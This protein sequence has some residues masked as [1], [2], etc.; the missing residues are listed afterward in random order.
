MRAAAPV[1]TGGEKLNGREGRLLQLQKHLRKR[2]EEAF[3]EVAERYRELFE[4]ANDIVYTT[5]LSG[6]FTSMNQAGLRLTGYPEDEIRKI[7]ITQ[8][9]SP[10]YLAVIRTMLAHI[11]AGEDPATFVIEIMAKDG[12]RVPLEVSNQL[13]VRGGKAVGFQGIGRN[14]ARRRQ[15]EEKN[16]RRAILMGRLIGLTE[17]LN[18]P[19]TEG[20]AVK[21]I[22]RGALRLSEAGRGALLVRQPDGTVACPWS[23]GISRTSIAEVIA[24]LHEL[25]AGFL[26]TRAIEDVV[27]LP[28]GS[29]ARGMKPVLFPDLDAAPSEMVSR[30]AREEGYRAAGVW[31][32]RSEGRVIALMGCYYD[33]PRTWSKPELDALRVFFRQAAV[34]LENARLHEARAQRTEELES[35]LALSTRLRAAYS[36]EEMYPLLVEHARQVLRAAYGALALLDEPRETFTRIHDTRGLMKGSG[37][38]PVRGSQLGRVVVT[39]VPLCVRDAGLEKDDLL[40][41]LAPDGPLGPAVV[42]PVRS[43]DEIIGALAIGRAQ[44]PGCRPFTNGDLSVLHG[45][46]EMGGTAIQRARLDRNLQ[47]ADVQMVLALAR[48]TAW[49]DSHTDLHNLRLVTLAEQIARA[50]GLGADEIEEIRWGARLHDIGKVGVPDSILHKPGPLTKR[51]QAVMRRH[52]MIG[53]EILARVERMRGVAKLVRHHQERWNG[54]GYPD[55]LA[56]DAIPSGARIL[57]VV[58]AYGAIIERRRYKRARSHEEAIAE[59]RR[60]AGSQFD[61]AIVKVFCRMIEESQPLDEPI[62]E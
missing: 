51:E 6:R 45:I 4:N 26:M 2:A 42:V 13:I 49:R 52:P 59:I 30:L 32:L 10:E 39:G 22:G 12:Q 16:H 5:D 57:A 24:H 8:V 11:L 31:P 61:P 53:E 48:A 1:E 21:A 46:T 44:G 55:G 3:H 9:V 23:R 7:D 38:I 25:P 50:L 40:P 60:G 47:Q 35:L 41:L 14:I 17:A 56:G 58:D 28:G 20:E 29:V 43:E 19:L 15:A 36:L 34:A 18:Q 33:A 54:T 62:A 27:E 37:T